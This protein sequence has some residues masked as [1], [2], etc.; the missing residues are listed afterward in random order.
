MAVGGRNDRDNMQEYPIELVQW[1]L[2]LTTRYASIEWAQT[3][4]RAD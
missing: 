4:Y 1:I 2:R 3:P